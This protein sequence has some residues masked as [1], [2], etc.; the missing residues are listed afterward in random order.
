[1]S[2]AESLT[3]EEGADADPKTKI[4]CPAC[5]EVALRLIASEPRPS[6]RELL[7]QRSTHLPGW[8]RKSLE[9]DDEKFWD[10]KY[11]A[12]FNA[13]YLEN[14]FERA[15][16]P[17]PPTTTRPPIQMLLPGLETHGCYGLD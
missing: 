12:G 16:Q 11:G 5:G 1:M 17:A 9:I 7:S 8:Y 6:W 4:K 13:W 10:V 2:P 3:D 14:I 15:Y